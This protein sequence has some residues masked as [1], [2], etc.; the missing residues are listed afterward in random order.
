MPPKKIDESMF[1]SASRILAILTSFE[2]D[3]HARSIK[4]IGEAMGLSISTTSRLVRLLEERAFLQK[5]P[6]TKKY[7]LGRS[8]FDLGQVLLGS[9]RNDISAI[10]K[11]YVDALRDTLGLSVAL[12]V[13]LGNS[14]VLA[15]AAWAANRPSF[16]P[17]VGQRMPIHIAAGAKAILAFSSP[18][19]VDKVLQGELARL[20]P[21]T[22]TDPEVLKARLKE[23]KRLGVAFDLGEGTLDLHIAAAPVFDHEKKPVA[24]VAAGDVAH[25][26]KGHFDD[27]FIA[28][29]KETAA[30][31]STR[32]FH[33][34]TEKDTN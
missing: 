5:D 9:L 10:A 27:A 34:A 12:E 30:K 29:L 24:A 16:S 26:I 31:I 1:R 4:E 19:F 11:P 2:P 21:N 18:E 3:N 32:L 20:T 15:Y 17:A 25:K 28:R 13:L 22:I 14:T 7:S 23:Y 6:W 8:V 33:N